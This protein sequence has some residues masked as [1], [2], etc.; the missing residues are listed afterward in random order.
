MTLSNPLFY[1]TESSD[2]LFFIYDLTQQQFT[3]MNP[4]CL[5]FFKLKSSDIKYG[6]L[7]KM[8]HPEDQQYIIAKLNACINGQTVTEAECRIRRGE[9]ER[10][11]RIKPYRCTENAEK[12]LIGQAEDITIYKAN[13]EILNNHN[14]KKN[15]IL[16]ILAHDLAGSISIVQSLSIMLGRET[17]HL[18]NP[19][20]E[21]YINMITG[22]SKSSSKLIQD[23]L[24][25]EFLESSTVKLLLKRVDLVEKIKITTAN[26]IA[27]QD[28]LKIE[29]IHHADKESIYAE[30]DEDKFMQVINNLISNA[31]KFTPDGG[32][33][34]ISLSDQEK[35]VLITVADNGIGIP[36]KFHA[37]LFEK[38]S[39]ARRTG[40][41][42]QHSTG[43]GMSVIKT[44]VEWH[45]GN[46][47]FESREKKGTAFYILLPKS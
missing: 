11:L 46:I 31:L 24:A 16:T 15:S 34:R 26:Y 45:K 7:L 41:K 22:I 40:L 30:I 4:A 6:Q 18:H 9:H 25:Q 13:T 37:V 36:E 14:H 35:E 17:A 33:I 2:E 3:Y 39:P 29:F 19:I 43:L 28:E 27:M 5:S 38:F 21:R 20:V 47:W 42:G 23:F 8:V 44:I 12:L 1:L 32:T 10:W